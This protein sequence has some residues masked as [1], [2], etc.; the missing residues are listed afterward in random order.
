MHI[1]TTNA[2]LGTLHQNNYLDDA[3]NTDH[4]FAH[5]VEQAHV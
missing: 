5:F 3:C 2:C 1:T 4:I